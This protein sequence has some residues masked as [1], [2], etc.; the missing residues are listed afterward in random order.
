VKASITDLR[1]ALQ[2]LDGYRVAPARYAYVATD[3]GR[4][5]EYTL[6]ADDWRDLGRRLRTGE[7]DAYSLWCAATVPD[8]RGAEK[9]AP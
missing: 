7:R 5:V 9:V 1:R 3:E 6:D 8:R 2:Y 4:Q